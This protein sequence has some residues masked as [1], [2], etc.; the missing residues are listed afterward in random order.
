MKNPYSELP[1]KSFWKLA[2]AQKHIFDVE[3]LWVPK[4]DIKP[5]DKVVTY[6]SCFAQHIGRALRSR[7]F[8]WFIAEKS[9]PGLSQENIKKYNYNL[10]SSRTGNI[11]TT[12]LL[13]QWV[14]WALEINEIPS[15]VWEDNGRFYDPFRPTVEP[16]GFSSKEELIESRNWT[17]ECFKESIVNADFFVFT[18]GLTERWINSNLSY[19]YPMCPGT[20]AGVFNDEVHSFDNL[21]FSQAIR[22]L[23]YSL[24]KMR[25]INPKLKF[26]LTVSPV[27]LTATK[28]DDHVLVATMASKSILRSIA[29]QLACNKNY[30]DYVPSY[31]IIN[32]PSFG[33]MFFEPNKR[34]VSKSGVS[35]V[36]DMFFNSLHNKFGPK[37]EAAHIDESDEDMDE[38]MDEAICE[39]ELLEAFAKK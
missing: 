8:D 34:S 23:A 22:A 13:Q 4:F 5:E 19:E 33:G 3:S 21:Q 9:I 12:T 38:N 27:P 1:E 10:F 35:F 18:L 31:E 25:K 14:N 20:A 2:I 30:V 11:Y 28:S 32:S 7:G 37:V 17:V 24:R 26:L 15:E 39:E 29:G 16:N 6:G 36:M